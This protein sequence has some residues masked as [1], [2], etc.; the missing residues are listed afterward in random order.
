MRRWVDTDLPGELPKLFID[1]P[2]F[3]V[4]FS[5]RFQT[6]NFLSPKA[7][8]RSTTNLD[9]RSL[10]PHWPRELRTKITEPQVLMT[11]E[12]LTMSY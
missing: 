3:P 4:T 8:S 11:K 6:Q 1:Q 2:T 5:I 12:E 9:R 7:R 10:R